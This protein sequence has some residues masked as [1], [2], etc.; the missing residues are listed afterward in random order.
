MRVSSLSHPSSCVLVNHGPPQQSSKE[1]Y[2]PCKILHISY[3]DHVTNE[4]VRAKIQQ[5]IRPHKDHLDIKKKLA[6]FFHHHHLSLN[7][8]GR[9]GTT[10]DF[11]TSFLH[12]TCS[13]LLSGTCRTPGL[14]IPWCCLHT[15]SS[16]CLVFFPLSPCLARW[17]WPDL[18]NRKHDHTTA[19]CISLRSSGGLRVV[20]LPAGSWRKL[21][22]W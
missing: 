6:D 16:V 2:K 8:E 15:S 1:E 9:R 5:A 11:A 20:Q 22:R 10:D 17:Y 14:S 7:R 19:V 3:T 21:P 12:F 18:M 13:P 4:E